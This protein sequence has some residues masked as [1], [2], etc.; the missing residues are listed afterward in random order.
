MLEN[1]CN[2]TDVRPIMLPLPYPS[3]QVEEENQAY[4]N[5]LSNDYCGAVSEL[6]AI[7]QYLNMENRLSREQCPIAKTILGIA[8]AEMI[9]LQKIGEMICLLGGDINYVAKQKD[10]RKREWTPQYL[11]FSDQPREMLS[12]GIQ[13][14]EDAIRQYKM[15]QNMIQDRYIQV[16]LARII[17]DEE[18]HIMLLQAMLND[19]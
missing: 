9:H 13:A 18:Y 6:S 10:G 7:T 1:I 8:M 14:E 17:K 3:C 15:H 19:L 4:A 11:V 12:L 16:M 5:I 2:F